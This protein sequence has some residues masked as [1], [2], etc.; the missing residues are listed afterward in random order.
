[1]LY[2]TENN[3]QIPRAAI[4]YPDYLDWKRQNT[5]LSS[6]DVYGRRSFTL[7]TPGGTEALMGARVSDGFFHT[8]GI[9]PVL[10]RDFYAGEDLPGAPNTVML[11]FAS[12]QTLFG[13]RPDIIG[14]AITL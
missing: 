3:A 7:K 2:V 4:S 13:G 11:S 6:L 14:Q 8:L 1:L 5:V 12:W 9:T 10:G